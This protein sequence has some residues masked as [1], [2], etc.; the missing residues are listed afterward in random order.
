MR[1]ISSD[2]GMAMR[3]SRRT[4]RPV[5]AAIATTVFGGAYGLFPIGW[6]I[7]NLIF[8][9]Q[10]TVKRGLFEVLR[11]SLAAGKFT[12][13]KEVPGQTGVAEARAGKLTATVRV[14]VA[15]V[16]GLHLNVEAI[17]EPAE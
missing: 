7:L 3:P 6:I 9:Y 4:G 13:A 17:G 1:A 10:L 16:N 14:R 11:G 5:K 2:P 8:L 15:S 12:A